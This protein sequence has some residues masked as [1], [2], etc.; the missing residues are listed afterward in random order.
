MAQPVVEAVLPL[1]PLQSGMLFH[2]SYDDQGDDVY[3][4]QTPVDLVGP[5]R[6]EDLKRAVEQLLHRHASLRAGFISR[7]SGEAVQAIARKTR[8]P[9][10]EV[11]LS[12]LD[13]D[14]QAGEFGKLLER[15]LVTRFNLA[16][17]PLVR[18]TLV[19]LAPE[20]HVLV[21][22]NHHI[23]LD[24]WSVPL[25]VQDLL[26]L[27][28]PGGTETLPEPAPFRDYLAWLTAQDRST[29]ESAWLRALEGLEQ[30]TLIARTDTARK[31]VRTRRVTLELAPDETAALYQVAR[32]HGVT[33]NTV[34]QSAW[35]LLMGQLTG[36]TDV[37]FGTVSSGRPPEL[38]G[39]EEMVG[40]FL[41]T[42]PVRAVLN[43]AEPV[44][45]LWERIQ[46]EQSELIAHQHLGLAGIQR[47]AGVGELFDTAVVF[48]NLPSLHEVSQFE[49]DRLQ[50]AMAQPDSVSGA[51]HY[52]LSLLAHPGERLK[53]DLSYR[54]D[55]LDR[56]AAK[57]IAGRLRKLLLAMTDDPQTA[58]GRL[59]FLPDQELEL[60]R[61]WN[62]PDA[63]TST[64]LPGTTLPEL[65]SRQV[66][67][68]P[69]AIALV[70]D[71]SAMTYA[72]FDRS[73]GRLARALLD[74]GAGPGRLVA[75]ALPRSFEM[76]VTLYAVHKTGAG[77]LPVDCSLPADRVRYMIE[78][79][80]PVLV[81]DPDTYR[82]LSEESGATD[83]PPV[84][85]L[86]DPRQPAY[87]IYTSGSTGRPKGVLV[88]HS[89]VVNRLKWQQ[90]RFPIGTGDRVLHK[91]PST[92]DVSVWELF[93]P[94]MV[95]GTL[96][97]ARPEGHKDPEYLAE[98]IRTEGIGTAHFVPSMLDPF[99]HVP[100]A[101]ACTSL[102]TV[103]CSGEALSQSLADRFHAVLGAELHNLYGPT[104]AA[105]EV[106]SWASQE[107][108]P[109]VSVPI[110]RPI[111][112]TRAHVLD[113]HLRPAPVGAPGELYLAG[114]QLAHGYLGRSG[115]T[116]ERFVADPFG[117]AGTRMYRT[118]DVVRWNEEGAL[119][120]E[121]RA[122]DQVKIRGLRIELGEIETLLSRHPSVLRAAVIV[123]EDRPGTKHLVAY[124]V[125][126]A[127]GVAP[128]ELMEH[129]AA[130]LPEYMLPQALVDMAE[131]PLT[132]SGKLDRRALPVPSF[133]TGTGRAPASAYE[134][135]LCGLFAEVLAL[136]S[137]GPDDNFFALGGDSLTAFRLGSQLQRT[138]GRKLPLRVI[139]E[140]PTP[141]RLAA[142]LAEQEVATPSVPS[143]G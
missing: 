109:G 55:V 138:A 38:A 59:D 102:R 114:V 28:V 47:A 42:I 85:G 14:E 13:A 104:E 99:L 105:V 29:A 60:L 40:L 87:L 113:A 115:L 86:P 117:P 34:V 129:L 9:W 54:P 43:S 62:A 8:V 108:R 7:K 124:V 53:M 21:F 22:T 79:A 84:P 116:A 123:R 15:D 88:P 10:C 57:R 136:P 49:G 2:A 58:T 46:D 94:L 127:G 128:E 134:E 3:V 83:G 64:D 112:R 12:G 1:T 77:Y 107:G 17:P 89:A 71:G 121:G 125:P 101:A 35:A 73:A 68:T 93:W 37:V 106:T 133:G 97:I 91:T 65:F 75:V 48:E 142:Y 80:A 98:L 27:Y 6:V 33:V 110:G 24:G 45:K 139:F 74:K 5:I 92:F 50:V 82:V 23:V 36:H 70:F 39:V 95:G 126:A 130:R 56:P 118:G 20:R 41:N 16:R 18:F 44:A 52:P 31:L 19:R 122:D 51:M 90:S 76:V 140:S 78:D 66:D 32:E 67:R 69:E 111:A 72:E 100:Q 30:G 135:L 119:V 137:V 25:V 4:M 120:F 26:K 132:S 131:L 143:A 103:I 141:C 63:I 11:D 81:V 96:V 61:A